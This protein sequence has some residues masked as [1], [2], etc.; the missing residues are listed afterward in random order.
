MPLTTKQYAALVWFWSHGPSR[1]A[2]LP[3][4]HTS[5]TV[6][7]LIDAGFIEHPVGIRD[8]QPVQFL[9]VISDKGFDAYFDRQL[10]ST[11]ARY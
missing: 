6:Q 3:A 1:L 10:P 4:E 8:L 11:S 7:S 5:A 2:S 9:Y